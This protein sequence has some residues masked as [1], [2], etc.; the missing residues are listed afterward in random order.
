MLVSHEYNTYNN[1][2]SK[3]KKFNRSKLLNSFQINAPQ[4]SY[5]TAQDITLPFSVDI[6]LTSL[7]DLQSYCNF[8]FN[9]NTY[10]CIYLAPRRG[11]ET[12]EEVDVIINVIQQTANETNIP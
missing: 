2:N 11:K 6:T 3:I 9:H 1:C 4:Q 7:P 12:K 10:S 5:D 8:L